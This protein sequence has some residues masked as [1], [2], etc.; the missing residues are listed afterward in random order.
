MTLNN[1]NSEVRDADIAI[2]G[3]SVNVPGAKNIDEF[4]QNLKNGVEAIQF[5][6]TE[7]VLASGVKPELA[8]NPNYVKAKAVVDDIDK[9]DAEFFGIHPREAEISDPQHRLFLEC[10]RSALEI[11][12]YDSQ[13]YDGLIGVYASAGISRYYLQNIYG[14]SELLKFFDDFQLYLANDSEFLATR[15]AYRLNLKGPAINVQTACSSSLVAVHL[16]CQ[17]LLSGE[18]DIALAGGV[19]LKVNPEIGYLYQE[20]MIQSPDGHCRA[21]DA[22]AKGTVGSGGVA[23]VALKRATEAIAD[24]DYIYA[25]I[26]G[27]AINNDGAVKVGYTAPS[28]EGQVNVILSAQSV[29]DVAPET[30]TYIE[31]HGTGTQLGDPIEIAALTQAF[32]DST[33]Q[34]QFCAIGS[35]KTNVGHLNSAAGVAGLIKTALAIKHQQIP[36]SLHFEHPNPNIDFA[37]SPFYVNTQLSPWESKQAPRRAGVSSFGIGGTNAHIILEE[38]PTIN[39]QNLEEKYPEQLLIL[40]AKN[41]AALE[42]ATENLGHHLQQHPDLELGDVTYT[43]R[44][45]RKAF[46][47]RR[48]V[49]AASLEEATN[50]LLSNAATL[51][52]GKAKKS[53]PPVIFMFS[54]QGSQ[55]VN[56]ARGLYEQEKV[57]RETVDRCAELLFSD[58]RLDLRSLIYPETEAQEKAEQQLQQTAIAQPALFTI[59]YA[60]AQLWQSWGIQPGGFI[61]HSVGEYVA[62]CLAGVFSLED[63]LS[64]IAARGKMIQQLPPGAMLSIPLAPEKVQPFLNESVAIAAINEP[65]RCVVSGT[66]DAISALGNQLKTQGIETRL[67]KTSHAFHSPMMEPILDAFSRRV[68]KV[69]LS[70]PQIPLVSNVTGN[71]MTPTQATDAKYWSKHVRSLVNFAGGIECFLDNPDQIL[72]EVGP[73]RTLSTF[74]KRHPLFK[75]T[76]VVLNS[77]RHPQ[78]TESDIRFVWKTLGQLWV[79]G[80]AVNWDCVY[81]DQLCP[82]IPLPTYPFQR[83]R[84]WVEPNKTTQTTQSSPLVIDSDFSSNSKPEMTP[85]TSNLV[86]SPTPNL[87]TDIK[88]IFAEISGLNPAALDES[89]T[90]LEMGFDSLILAQITQGLEKRF[91]LKLTFRQLIQE[92]STLKLLSDYLSAN[93]P[94]ELVKPIQ[95]NPIQTNPI[96]TT[97]ISSHPVT[98]QTPHTSPSNQSDIQSIITQQLQVMS[99]QLAVLRQWESGVRPEVQNPQKGNNS[100]TNGVDITGNAQPETSPNY[101]PLTV[102]A[103]IQKK[104]KQALTPSQQNFLQELIKRYITKTTQSK[105][106]TQANRSHFADPRTVSGFNPTLKE[107]V[108]PIITTRSAGAKLWDIDGNEYIDLVNGFGS[109]FLGHSSPLIKDAIA[110]QLEKGIEI[111]PMTLLAGE[112]AQ[113]ICQMTHFDRATFCNTGSEAVLG[114]MRIARTVTNRSKIAIFSGGYHGICDEVIVRPT[115]DYR[116]IPAACGIMPEALQNMVVVDYNNP[117]SLKILAEF[118]DDLAAILIEPV[119]SRYPDIQPQE[120]LHQLR[121]LCDKSGTVLIFDEMITGFRIHPSGAQAAFGVQADIATYGKIVGGG[122]PIGVIAGKSRFMD[123]LDG[124]FWQ[125]GDESVPEVGVTFLAGTFVRHPL[126]MAAA[127]AIL[128]YFQQNGDKLHTQLNQKTH[129]M[130]TTLNHYFESIQAPLK[131]VNFGSLVMVKFTQDISYPE[132]LFYLL[133]SRGIYIQENRPIFLTLAHSDGE[134]QAVIDAFCDSVKSLQ[135]AG[136][137]GQMATATDTNLSKNPENQPPLPGAKL[138]RDPQGNPGWYFQDQETGGYQ[139]IKSL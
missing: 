49:V 93:L 1:F 130:V 15:T 105:A 125:Y 133:R 36:P 78:E 138:G 115:Q 91:K 56:M 123:A 25:L 31:A 128:S 100:P 12:G 66:I 33:E 117:E 122:M 129:Q 65:S 72:L 80:V 94:P 77:V 48:I 8:Y 16:A 74:V 118:A 5:F 126:A 86:T 73:G 121:Q 39:N 79:N 110:T 64:L 99:E 132:L 23:I 37:N 75:A 43:L 20:G 107:I 3:M 96:Q 6:S 21:F 131:M 60:L 114:A 76:Q 70:S 120:F 92:F 22:Q 88:E 98:I 103:K 32:R 81:Q 84:Y 41:P 35:L 69:K 109:N 135:Q 124:G 11:A 26:K 58:L 67:L 53:T 137:F 116:A 63:A 24:G 97:P 17:G 139:L 102:G 38:A 55:Y 30:I 54:G 52:T 68:A 42:Q 83:Q 82:R 13:S 7:E 18:C 113:L 47:H 119:Q 95:T 45:G 136:F 112:V 85:Q 106:Y 59:E 50:H 61:G 40:S 34:T 71:W 44:V 10:A 57:F 87:M 9:F 46:E 14:N 28:V 101:K 104:P 51:V 111:G 127:K 27:S 4:W 62:A 2:I 19:T 89:S 90:F 29:A 108:Y 134:I